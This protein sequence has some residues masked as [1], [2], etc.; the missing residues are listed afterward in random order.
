MALDCH[1]T[2]VIGAILRWRYP[3]LQRGR[4]QLAPTNSLVDSVMELA[5]QRRPQEDIVPPTGNR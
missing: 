2:Q 5:A 3:V 1:P 4:P